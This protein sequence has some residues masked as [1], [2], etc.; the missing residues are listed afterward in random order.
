MEMQLLITMILQEFKLSK[1]AGQEV[2]KEPLLTMRQS[3]H[4]KMTLTKRTSL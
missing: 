1:I 4:L 3:P 2:K